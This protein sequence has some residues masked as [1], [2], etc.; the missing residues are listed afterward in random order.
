M[1]KKDRRERPPRVPE[2]PKSV[3]KQGYQPPG[4]PEKNPRDRVLPKGPRPQAPSTK[5]A[6][7]SPQSAPAEGKQESDD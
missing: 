6:P 4:K 3:V 1:A 7:E 2:K 5:P